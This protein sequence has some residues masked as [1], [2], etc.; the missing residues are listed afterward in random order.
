MYLKKTLKVHENFILKLLKIQNKRKF[1]NTLILNFYK[2]KIWNKPNYHLLFNNNLNRV[3]YINSSYN[4][5]EVTKNTN[6][7]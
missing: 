7:K 4:L 6:T 5:V 1:K 2:K 3:N